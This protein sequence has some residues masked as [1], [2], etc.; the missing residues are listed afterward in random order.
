MAQYGWDDCPP[1]VRSQIE[2]VVW[3]TRRILDP[4]LTGIYLHGS[5]AMRCFNPERSDIDLLVVTSEPMRLDTKLMIGELLLRCSNAPRPIEISFLSRED[6]APWQHPTPFDLHY[7]ED[8]RDLYTAELASGAWR[9]WNDTRRKDPDLAA[10][11]TITHHR[12][13]CLH[14]APIAAVFPKVPSEDYAASILAD[15]AGMSAWIV[16]EPV[17]CTLN[18]CRV[19]VYLRERRIASKDEGGA[20]GLRALP[21]EHRPIV[22]TAL[23]VYRGGQVDTG[24]DE[25]ALVRFARYIE[26]AIAGAERQDRGRVEEEKA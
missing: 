7:G 16:Q 10:H 24:F 3:S 2:D 4:N 15:V 25:D 23:E 22:G 9:H 5:L 11:I 8:W 18:L 12:G 1:A 14:G 19:L 26:Q 17:Y 21:E 6:L 13:I 20:W